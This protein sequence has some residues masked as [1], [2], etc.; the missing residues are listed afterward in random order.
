[1]LFKDVSH[2]NL[3]QPLYLAE[4]NHLCNFGKIPR[5]DQFCEFF[6]LN[7]TSGSGGDVI[8]RFFYLELWWP[9]CSANKA[10]SAIFVKGIMRNNSVNYFEF[11][12]VVQEMSF[13]GISYLEL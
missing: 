3:W 5:E 6:F 4:Q 7:L 9:F 11:G 12:S 8:K 1:M 10:I 2:Q 13:K